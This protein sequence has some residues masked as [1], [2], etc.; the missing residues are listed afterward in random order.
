MPVGA[1]PAGRCPHCGQGLAGEVP[2][3]TGDRR[4]ALT[5]DLFRLVRFLLV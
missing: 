1:S 4:Q 5:A 2:T 3:G